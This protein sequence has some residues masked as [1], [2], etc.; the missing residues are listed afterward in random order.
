[1]SIHSVGLSKDEA[2]VV[3]P[4]RAQ[5]ILDI[6]HTRLYQLIAARELESYNE[7]RSRKITMRWVKA[8]VER[9]LGT[10]EAA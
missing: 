3:S 6:G 9:Q 10:S 1:V 7:G 8:Y 4:K 2:L 5:Q